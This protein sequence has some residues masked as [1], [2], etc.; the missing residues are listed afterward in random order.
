MKILAFVFLLPSFF[1]FTAPGVI[2]QPQP[3]QPAPPPDCAQACRARFASCSRLCG[4]HG[5]ECSRI[6]RTRRASCMRA[7]ESDAGAH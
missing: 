4:S 5:E 1:S 3:Q 6:C 7:C 2:A